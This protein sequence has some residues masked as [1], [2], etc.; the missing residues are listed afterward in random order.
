MPVP[1]D[2]GVLG[3]LYQSSL[4]ITNDNESSSRPLQMTLYNSWWSTTIMIIWLLMI[5]H[6]HDT[7]EIVM[8]PLQ[9]EI[10]MVV[11]TTITHYIVDNLQP[12]WLLMLN[13]ASLKWSV[14]V[15]AQSFGTSPRT[16]PH[17]RIRTMAAPQDLVFGSVDGQIGSCPPVHH[18]TRL[19]R[20]YVDW[21]LLNWCWLN[22]CTPTGTVFS[23]DSQV[24][25]SMSNQPEGKQHSWKPVSCL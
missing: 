21:C 15:A 2:I 18:R 8:E 20:D 4:M 6:Y 19:W 1:Q 9:W 13:I 14:R 11:I 7:M 16:S 3:P 24:C 10:I 17:N 25:F 12:Q 5:N 22:T 23:V